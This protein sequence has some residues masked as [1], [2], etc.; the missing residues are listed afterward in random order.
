MPSVTPIGDDETEKGS[1]AHVINVVTVVFAA[2]NSDKGSPNQG[3]K[4]KEGTTEVAAAMSVAED[5][6]LAG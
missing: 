4:T 2:A 5:A 1:A 3:G 6:E